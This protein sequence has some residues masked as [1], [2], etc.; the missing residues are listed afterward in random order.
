MWYTNWVVIKTKE[1]ASFL[2]MRAR[3][4]RVNEHRSAI[5]RKTKDY[6]GGHFSR[7]HGKNPAAHLTVIG[8]E[9]VL[10]HHDEELL[11][12]RESLWINNYDSVQF[13]A[14]TRS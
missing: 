1:S 13:G 5:N 11:R 7:G 14:N 10:P 8:I 3:Q 2:I 4:L 12:T 6:L 9:K